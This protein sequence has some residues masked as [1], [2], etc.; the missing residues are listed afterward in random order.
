MRAWNAGQILAP[1]A[2]A[3]HPEDVW[4]SRS[5][6]GP[7]TARGC[8]ACLPHTATRRPAAGGPGPGRPWQRSRAA[9]VGGAD[10]K[11][12]PCPPGPIP[13]ALSLGSSASIPPNR[14]GEGDGAA[15][16]S[17]YLA[18]SSKR[19]RHHGVG[20]AAQDLYT[21]V[22]LGRLG[23]GAQAWGMVGGRAFF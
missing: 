19:P 16:L 14:N 23:Q 1:R 8:E 4:C 21:F 9:R 13:V 7:H 10:Q 12:E 3:H 11:G 2:E 18:F 20:R 17:P 15:A 5:T 22:F 6:L